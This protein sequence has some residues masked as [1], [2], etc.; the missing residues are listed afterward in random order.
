MLILNLNMYLFAFSADKISK[1]AP[2]DRYP[3]IRETLFSAIW[4]GFQPSYTVG[5]F[6]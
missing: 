5:I 1:W 2:Q 4:N 6:L 3:K